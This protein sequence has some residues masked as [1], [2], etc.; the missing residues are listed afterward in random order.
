MEIRPR[1]VTDFDVG[2]VSQAMRPQR[3]A[4]CVRV[5][6]PKRLTMQVWPS[7]ARSNQLESSVTLGRRR[8]NAAAQ[9]ALSH[10][11]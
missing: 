5:G 9:R 11:R 6:Q 2:G 3:V 7:A 8:S 1:I 10:R 4:V